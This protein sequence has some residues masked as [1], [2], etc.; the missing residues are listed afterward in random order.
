MGDPGLVIIPARAVQTFPTL[1]DEYDHS[2][3][4]RMPKHRVPCTS[5]LSY[6]E[7]I[8]GLWLH[9][10]AHDQLWKPLFQPLLGDYALN[11]LGTSW[12]CIIRLNI[13]WGRQ[14]GTGSHTVWFPKDNP[15]QIKAKVR[16]KRFYLSKECPNY[17]V[18]VVF[19]RVVSQSLFS[20]ESLLLKYEE[21]KEEERYTEWNWLFLFPDSTYP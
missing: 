12:V 8:S 11:L 4:Q 15:N 20:T 16:W 10:Q 17:R 9:F 3:E 14:R 21:I 18:L 2:C 5:T 13:L 7:L 19:S 6:C 1:N